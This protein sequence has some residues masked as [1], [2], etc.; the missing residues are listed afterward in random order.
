MKNQNILISGASIAGPTLAYWLNRHG[1]HPT[2]VERAP[3]PREGGQA[4]DV[5]GVALTV[6]E[7]MG[8]LSEVRGAHTR[9]RGM[10]FVDG[11]GNQLMSTTEE[12]LTGGAIDSDDVELMRDDLTR[13]LHE[14]TRHDV[15]YRFGD[16]ITSLTQDEEGVQ[17]TF[18][19]GQTRTFDLVIGADGLH[20]NVR[21]LAFGEESRYIRHL[22]IYLAIFSTANHLGL[23]HWQVFHQTPGKMAGVYS[24][25]RNTEARAMLGFES[26]PLDFD[27]HDIRQQKQLVADR[28]ADMGW[29]T[30]RLLKAMWEASDFYFDSMSQIHMD[31]WWNG[32]TALLGDAGY[33]G[34]PMSGQGTS[35]AMVGAYV[36]AG[37]LAAAAGE[38]RTAFAQYEQRMRGYVE[39]NQKLATENRGQRPSTEVLQ[40]AANAITLETY[41]SC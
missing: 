28:F 25:R 38:H 12:T 18:A 36:L 15:E 30:P 10:S 35:M 14:A 34:S 24:A 19:R 27:R 16:S 9:M 2:V 41:P 8:L 40:R 33:C 21:A 7:R 1:F 5:R 37:E 32:R 39:H 4:I 11:E 29:E 6:T 26:P 20:S 3:A 17:V 23:D 13:I 22:G 31:R